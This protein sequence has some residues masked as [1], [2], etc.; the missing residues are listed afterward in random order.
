MFLLLGM[1]GTALA[2]PDLNQV[3]NYDDNGDLNYQFPNTEGITDMGGEA[4]Y[5]TDTDGGNDDMMATIVLEL[6]GNAAINHFGIYGYTL[7]EN[8]NVTLGNTLEV[9]SGSD[10][11]GW[12]TGYQNIYVNNATGEYALEVD[13]E[14]NLVDA[15]A[16]G[17]SFGFYLCGADGYIYSHAALNGGENLML[18]F[19]VNGTQVL[20]GT[21]DLILAFED[22]F[23]GDRDYNDFVVAGSDV[24]PVPEPATL[25]LLG[26][27]LLGLAGFRRRK[28]S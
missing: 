27:G 7:G 20:G 10:S 16:L 1:T 3:L 28:N 15:V 17:D 11:S 8:G 23:G 14:G 6:A 4:A 9:F 24:A 26:S 22:T 18:M 2:L 12:A 25:L 19:D 13:D 21:A 5:C